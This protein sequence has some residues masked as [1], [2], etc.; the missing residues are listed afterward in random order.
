MM[1]KTKL[2]SKKRLSVKITDGVLVISIGIATLGTAIR[3]NPD[4]S[5]F[6]EVTRKDLEPTITDATAFG[7]ELVRALED[8]DEEGSTPVHL[9]LDAAVVSAIENGAEGILTGDDKLDSL[10]RERRT[11]AA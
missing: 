6:D 2:G 10:R 3:Y 4:L 9:M 7:K 5:A 1:A 8:E 11:G